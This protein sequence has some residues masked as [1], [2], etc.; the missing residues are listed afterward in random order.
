M[1]ARVGPLEYRQAFGIQ[2]DPG[3]SKARGGACDEDTSVYT[4]V[5][6]PVSNADSLLVYE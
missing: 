6:T 1:R 2:L 3:L 5:N 4:I